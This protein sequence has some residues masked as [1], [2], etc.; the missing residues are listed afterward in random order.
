MWN[1]IPPSSYLQN[2]DNIRSNGCCIACIAEANTLPNPF[3]GLQ[4]SYT[5]LLSGI[6]RL[7]GLGVFPIP[8]FFNQW[9][10][11]WSSPENPH[12]PTSS[13]W[14]KSSSSHNRTYQD[15]HTYGTQMNESHFTCS[16]ETYEGHGTTTHKIEQ[17]SPEFRKEK[18]LHGLIHP[19]VEKSSYSKVFWKTSFT[20]HM[21]CFCRHMKTYI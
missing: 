4:T 19:A 14:N 5:I 6:T 11:W 3:T 17:N 16:A 9:E 8:A 21:I 15:G 7:A 10:Q 13:G 2:R 20:C 18:D 12:T 1:C